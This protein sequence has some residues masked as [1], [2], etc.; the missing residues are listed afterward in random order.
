[1]DYPMPSS[2]L[3]EILLLLFLFLLLLPVNLILVPAL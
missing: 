2:L 1:M 3:A